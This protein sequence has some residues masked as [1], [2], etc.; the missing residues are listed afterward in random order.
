[1][2]PIPIA[3]HRTAI[4][5]YEPSRPIRLALEDGLVN[6]ETSVFDYGCGKGDDL[7]HL[8]GRGIH[9]EGWDPAHYPK[10]NRVP[11]DVV[12]LGYVVNVIENPTERT[13]ALREAWTLAQKLLVVSARLT[14]EVTAGNQTPHGDG[15]LTRLGTFQ[16][17]YEQRELREW[18]DQALGVASVPVAPGIFYVFR[19]PDLG[20][21]F[22]ASRYRRRSTA[23]RQRRSDILFEQHKALFEPLIAFITSRGR[24]PDESELGEVPLICQAVG[25][26]NRAFGIIRRVTGDEEWNRI[27]EERLQDLLLYLAL[28]RFDGRP[29]FT[30]LSRDLQL[31]VRA[32]FSTYSRACTAADALLFSAGNR[33]AVDQACRTAPVGKL[34]PG[35]LYIH[36]AALSHLPPILRAYEGCARTYIGAVEGANIVKLHRGTPQVSY[37]SYPEFERDPHP[38]LAASLIVRLQTFRLQSRD[39]RN[40]SNPPI[41][42]RKEE[43]VPPDYFLRPKFIRLTRQEEKWGLYE[44]PE[45]IGTREGWERILAEQ[46]VHLSGHRLLRKPS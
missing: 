24:F 31:D 28:A 11:A 22:V 1:M 40:S 3:R 32:F 17:Y 10:G 23:P 38:A 33:Q 44:K 37:L 16:K 9:C 14:V 35:A 7:R 13:V 21:S 42:H 41:L 30:Q 29:R 27:R 45:I 2:T 36:T 20:Q 18:I 12:N 39:Y 25:N 6:H 15:C 4:S 8:Q 43:F 26:L 19:D 5:R 46:S 34:T